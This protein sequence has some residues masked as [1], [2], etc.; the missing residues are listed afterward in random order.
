MDFTLPET[1][2]AVRDLAAD[3]ATKISSDDRVAALEASSAPLDD[4]LWRELASAG[5]LAL[6]LPEALAGDIAGDLTTVE[7][8]TVAEQLGR[9]LARVPFGQ[10]ATAAGPLLARHAAVSLTSD[11]LPRLADGTLIATVAVE[12][13]LGDDTLCPTATLTRSEHGYVLRGTKIN[14]PF[15]AAAGLLLIT[16]TDGD[17]AA[18]AVVD[19][20][21]N[22]ITVTETRT[23]GLTPMYLLELSD[24]AVDDAHVLHGA[25][26]VSDL[27]DR[28]TLALCAEQSGVLAA[29]LEATASYARER[30][31]FGRPIGSFQAVAQRL[32]DGYID[33]SALSLT[34]TQASWM[35]AQC[36]AQPAA[37]VGRSAVGDHAEVSAAIATAK[38]W[39]AE[40]GHRVAHTAVHVH[41]GVGLDTSH[42]TH[43]YFL[44]AKQNEFTLGSASTALRRLGDTLAADP[45]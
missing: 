18:V 7:N 8:T 22:G 2:T 25:D 42:P 16:A 5:L 32:A 30:E 4:Q 3:I 10:H 26:V 15:A 1:A 9:R 19:A 20:T 36:D 35:L 41:G 31:Q 13:D 21:A 38:F 39:A 11:L 28:L 34:T 37:D 17:G 27:V 40:S 12:E 43:R 24:V 44:R 33:V 23:T 29:A 45:A 6:E 14:V